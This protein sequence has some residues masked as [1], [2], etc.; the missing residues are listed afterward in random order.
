MDVAVMWRFVIPYIMR[1]ERD[2]V[3]GVTDCDDFR[4][5]RFQCIEK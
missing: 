5:K 2:S 3:K 4:L 1:L